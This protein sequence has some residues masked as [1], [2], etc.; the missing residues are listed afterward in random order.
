M[1]RSLYQKAKMAE[2][3]FQQKNPIE[4]V[5]IYPL[6]YYIISCNITYGWI[7]NS[8]FDIK[9]CFLIFLNSSDMTSESAI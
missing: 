4:Q 2:I 5:I 1:C 6:L 9:K 3:K 7:L 8:Y